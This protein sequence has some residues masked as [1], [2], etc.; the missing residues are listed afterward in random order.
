MSTGEL[1][2]QVRVLAVDDDEATVSLTAT[3]LRRQ[4]DNFSVL[5]VTSGR[6][7]LETLDRES[8]DCVV[9]DYEM[10][11]MDGIELLRAVRDR[12]SNLPFI[13]FTGRGSEEIASE[14][15][16]A[17]V[18]DYLQKGSGEDRYTLLANRIENAV[19][20]RRAERVARETQ[21]RLEE[22]TGHTND[23]LYMFD[24]EFSEL[25]FV[26]EP[27]E[28][29]YGQSIEEI[30]ANPQAFMQ[31][32]HPADRA[33]V[34]EGVSRLTKGEPVKMEYR[35][36]EAE[37]YGRWVEVEGTPIV[38]DGEV[39]RIVG[40]A[41]DV[42][43][44]RERRQRIEESRE[45][46]RALFE[47][48]PDGVL[49]TDESGRIVQVN[50]TFVNACGYD[51]EA[52][53]SMT[54]ADL[55][56]DNA[57]S[58]TE[59]WEASLDGDET[60]SFESR[61]ERADGT[62]T[63]VEVWVT[64]L[65][66]GEKRQ[67]L[68]TIRDVSE[69]QAREN[70]LDA[71]Y[72]TTRELL[73]ADD[74]TA[75]AEIVVRAATDVLDLQLNSVYAPT[76]AG[77]RLVPLATSDEN[78]VMFDEQ[79][80]FTPGNSIAW[81]VY[82]SGEERL[83]EDVSRDPERHNE[84][85]EIRTE[86][87]LPL[88]EHGVFIAG[89]TEV[90]AFDEGT[91]RLARLLANTVET[92]L[93]RT[94]SYERVTTR[95]RKI[96]QLQERTDE[97]IRAESVEAV[98]EVAVDTAETVLDM[99]F[100]GIH[101]VDEAYEELEPIAVSQAVVDLLGEAPS[102][103]RNDPA[104]STDHFNWG[105]FE[106]G[107]PAIFDDTREVEGLDPIETPSRS[108]V[109]YP[110]GDHGVFVSTAE[111]PGA[112]SE[113]DAAL[114]ELFAAVVTAALDQ[115]ASRADLRAERNLLSNIFEQIP[116]HL[117]VKDTEGRHLR[118]ST[119]LFEDADVDTDTLGVEEFSPSAVQGKTDVDLYGDRE[120]YRQSYADDL[121]VIET[122]EPL[123]DVEGYDPVFEE[124]FL[125]S[126]VPWYDED[127]TCKGI[128]GV[129]TE[130]T[131]Q[132]E[133]E[134][135]L[136]RQNDRLDNFASM[137]SHDLRNPLNVV[138]GRLELALADGDETHLEPA[139]RAATRMGE[140]IDDMLWL[141][142]HGQDLD[143]VESVEVDAVVHE[144]WSVV[145]TGSAALSVETDATVRADRSRL[146]QVFEN[147]FRNA[148]EHAGPEVSVTV[149]RT[150]DAIYVADDG[151]GIPSADLATATEIGYSGQPD[152]TG[153]GLAIVDGV[154]TAHGWTLELGESEAGGLRVEIADVTFL[155]AT[156]AETPTNSSGS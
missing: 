57:S 126:K 14:A 80:V 128:M 113:T 144:A 35:V 73:A 70:R 123:F 133:Y 93:D 90:A 3:Y 74:R 25:L 99:P 136:E 48:S 77:D 146:A 149:G 39:E 43:E 67:Y 66:V 122:G 107:Q 143:G 63:P 83:Y 33:R 105:V 64:P 155:D 40:A 150:P 38:E 139:L 130:I 52:L 142:K 152:G 13:L 96:Q 76:A 9:S 36:N 135:Q 89:S 81:E 55:D 45:R 54:I 5:T 23:V 62:I 28:S 91:I 15:I 82:E 44:Q 106:S 69:W 6:E 154:A 119:H 10:P 17:G 97:L 102:Y 129:A 117:F 8:I 30:E 111:T 140:L 47:E 26:N 148:V 108:G 127:D 2:G 11:T 61:Y 59:K 137:V 49:V 78:D 32:I 147:L 68:A 21:H 18:T 20:Q 103:S 121:R 92:V 120:R 56:A 156:P 131:T 84:N 114:V 118:V 65:S 60:V 145:D 4:R 116:V 85:T 124:W 27:Y 29:V 51:R 72:R 101:L 75:I 125:T 151:P 50:Q 132:K 87:L 37:D 41:R 100:N 115:L 19:K 46:F 53:Q 34:S 153:L 22:V 94:A 1:S 112:L 141:A 79:P 88:G 71:L 138:Q 16:S 42:T 109:V 24:A 104:R 95:N 86:M 7:A 134:R 58:I 110:L 31:C 12:E 98:A